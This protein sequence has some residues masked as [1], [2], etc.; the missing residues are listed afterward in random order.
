MKR[1]APRRTPVLGC[2][3]IAA[4]KRFIKR[5]SGG[6]LPR[7]AKVNQVIAGGALRPSESPRSAV[8]VS[9]SIDLGGVESVWVHSRGIE[10]DVVH[11]AIPVCNVPFMH[12]L[13]TLI[14]KQSDDLI[15][16]DE[17]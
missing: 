8:E 3:L 12:E 16:E 10:H 14:P 7:Q 2:R 11:R 5:I 9:V 1:I 15:S 6:V 17:I 4:A 13:Y